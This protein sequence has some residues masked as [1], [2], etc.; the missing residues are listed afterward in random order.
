MSRDHLQVLTPSSAP[1][2]K[3]LHAKATRQ[4][5]VDTDVSEDN[6]TSNFR[7]TNIFLALIVKFPEK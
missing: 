2:R 3:V 1:A 4:R 5:Y 7:D 6:T